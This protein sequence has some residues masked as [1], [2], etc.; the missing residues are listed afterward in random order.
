MTFINI[1]IIYLACGSPFGVYQLTRVDAPRS[2]SELITAAAAFIL[3]PVFLIRFVIERLSSHGF[4][5]QKHRIEQIRAGLERS[6]LRDSDTASV[7]EFREAFY[8]YAGLA[9]AA[10]DDKTMADPAGELIAISGRKLDTASSNCLS[11]RS[12]EKVEFHLVQARNDFVEMIA[13]MAS[14]QRSH[15]EIVTLGIELTNIIGDAP[16]TEDL[17]ALQLEVLPAGE[18]PATEGIWKEHVN[19]ASN[20]G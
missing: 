9:G 13:N 16:A 12:R 20:I 7:F 8:R 4:V 18:Q 19:S 3:W 1:L 15:A 14:D 11:R 17:T 10:A 2:S 5:S 6:G